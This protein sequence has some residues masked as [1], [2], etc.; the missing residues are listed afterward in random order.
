MRSKEIEEVLHEYESEDNEEG[1]YD[2]IST[3]ECEV[4]THQ[5]DAHKV[6]G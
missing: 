3:R 6:F 4:L 1:E 5:S 2:D